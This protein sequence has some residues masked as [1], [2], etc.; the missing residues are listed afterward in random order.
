[1]LLT[2]AAGV[3]LAS[4]PFGGRPHYVEAQRPGLSSMALELPPPKPEVAP[5]SY[6]RANSVRSIDFRNFTYPGSTYGESEYYSPEEIFTLRD[7]TWGGPEYGMTLMTVSYG[8]V[9]GDGREEAIL[10][11][12]Q[13]NDGSAGLDSVYVYTLEDKRPKVLWVFTSGDRA[14][15]GL[16]RAYA[17]GGKL[18]VELYGKETLIEGSSATSSTETGVGL[19]CPKFFTRTSYEWASG[20]FRQSGPMEVLP[21]PAAANRK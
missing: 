19:C 14:D 11:F 3:M 13:D 6:P 5:L 10:D 9:T 21:D 12:R 20:R 18:R 1:M 15:G 2:F 16:R 8:D 17:V 4:L 7:G